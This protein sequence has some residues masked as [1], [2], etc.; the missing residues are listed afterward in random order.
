MIQVG[1]GVVSRA[2]QREHG[3]P[4]LQVDHLCF[5]LQ[6]W[7]ISPNHSGANFRITSC[8]RK[9]NGRVIVLPTCTILTDIGLVTETIIYE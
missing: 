5:G 7:R 6:P 9:Y 1:V 2:E 3:A 4:K 8:I